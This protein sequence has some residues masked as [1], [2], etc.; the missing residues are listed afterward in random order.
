MEKIVRLLA[1]AVL[2]GVAIWPVR[3]EAQTP[4]WSRFYLGGQ[5]GYSWDQIDLATSVVNLSDIGGEL[6]SV[7]GGLQGGVNFIQAN[8]VVGGIVAD[9][10]WLAVL[11]QASGTTTTTTVIDT[12]GDGCLVSIDTTTNTRVEIE[13]AW[14]SS[15]RGKIGLLTAPN[16]LLYATGGVAF[17]RLNLSMSQTPP[18]TVEAQRLTL[19]GYAAG[20]GVETMVSSN[21]SAFL[22]VLHY[23]F[24]DRT[25]GLIGQTVNVNLDETIVEVG[26]SYYFN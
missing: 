7:I 18:G 5:V 16:F 10:N 9:F 20:V 1:V 6:Q 13:V 25:L 22:Q 2:A 8:G 11:G 23:D 4:N 19:V 26:A 12:C 15:L 21:L 3:A 14:K 24:G 17:A